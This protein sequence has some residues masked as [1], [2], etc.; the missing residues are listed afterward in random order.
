[1]PIDKPA[2]LYEEARTYKEPEYNTPSKYQYEYAVKDEY[3]GVHFGQNEARDGYSTYGEYMVSLPDCRT[4]IVK[5][6]TVDEYS[7][8][9]MEVT[10][11]GNP[12]YETYKQVPK[13]API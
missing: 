6:Q 5:Y 13:S 7:G 10:Y 12:C 1:M 8:N 2:P 3:S 11:E 9:I 4:Q